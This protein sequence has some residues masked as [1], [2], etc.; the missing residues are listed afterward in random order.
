MQNPFGNAGCTAVNS[1]HRIGFA[2]LFTDA[3]GRD[4]HAAFLN[5]HADEGTVW[6]MDQAGRNMV[7]HFNSGPDK[8]KIEG[9]SQPLGSGLISMVFETEQAFSE[10]EIQRN[11]I[12]DKRLDIRVGK[13][14]AAL[15]AVPFIVRGELCGVIS[16]VQ[17]SGKAR[18][19]EG[20]TGSDLDIVMRAE[21]A[22]QEAF[23]RSLAAAS[24]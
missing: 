3:M 2:A 9:F 11:A 6:L 13:E 16:C 20:F 14:T 23:E 8:N 21:A 22:L 7:A 5:A 17:L 4:L 15:I 12:Q 19:Q 10:N 1:I 18:P 24:S